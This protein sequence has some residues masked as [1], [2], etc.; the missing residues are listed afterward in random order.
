[1]KNTDSRGHVTGRSVYVDDIPE[2]RGT[3]YG[4]VFTSPVAHGKI[5]KLNISAARKV[6]GVRAILTARDIPGENQIGGAIPDEPLF[7]EGMVHFCGQPMALVVA[8]SETIARKAA[9]LIKTEIVELPAITDARDAYARGLFL[10]KPG[11]FS[12]GDTDKA[13][14]QC[15]HIFEGRAD[16]GG[17][18]HLYIETQGSYAIPVEND[19][20][21]IHASTQA[22]THVQKTTAKVLGIPMHKVEVDVARLGGGFGG[23]EDQATAYACMAALAAKLT[24]CP[25]KIILHRM[26]DMRMTGKRHPYSADFK[27]GLAEDMRI[28]AYEATFYQNGGAAADLSAA[29]LDRS[30]FHST[31]CYFIPNTRVTAHS[32]KTNLP[33]NT[34]FRG[35]GGPQGMFI[36]ESAIAM[37]ARSLN[38]PARSIQQKNFL[39]EG[40]SFQYGQVA[41]K[42]HIKKSYRSIEQEFGIEKTGRRIAAY[43]K[44]NQY[45]KKGMAIMP[46]C[47]GISFTTKAMNQAR[48]L[49]HI[50]Q[51]G[52]VGV[53]TGAV[54][55]GQGVNTKIMQVAAQALSVGVERIKVESTN[56]TRVS[57]TSPTAASSG[58]DLN[59]KAT[60]IACQQLLRRLKKTAADIMEVAV[61]DIS[62]GD[63]FVWVGGKKT[64][65]SWEE[66]IKQA[67]WQ[68]V[69]LS[70][71][72]HYI[73]PVIHFDKSTAKGHPFA[74]HVYGSAL[75][76]VTV[77]CIRGT[78]VVDKVC[79]VH[80]FGQSMNP[81]I[82]MGQLEGAV[83][84][85]LGWMTMEEISFG[86]DGKLLSNS[87]STYKVPD[88]YSVPA[89]INCIPLPVKGPG[90]AI[91][92]S[93]AIGEPPLMYGIGAFFALQDAILAFNKQYSY[94]FHAPMT[95]EKVL[96]GLYQI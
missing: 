6:K 11:V 38:I 1:M 80:D 87:L 31:N 82:D 9:S 18:E 4:V 51:D 39:A 60:Q 93:K 25:V 12:M 2:L 52:S 26:D 29:I 45:S 28:L 77:D 62:I 46:I 44:K 71:Q 55:M 33:P 81:S 41:R 23:K 50:Y 75:W 63:E 48:S 15:T 91:L 49:V 68:R 17:Q 53:S 69:C 84:Q 19:G 42:V 37:A 79:I 57:N 22:P 40:D 83:V 70:E 94:P 74:Y 16:C 54:E 72:G 21:R 78:Y 14:S 3:Q 66:L 7:A 76:E 35:F 64:G 47:F 61:A 58:A 96:M 24:S 59:G 27:I 34:A 90:E 30:L 8:S 86:A 5:R 13:W 20:I 89:E 88:I 32:C 56:T 73:T 65:L 10:C 36:M 43:N 92:R 85:G 95:P 67:H